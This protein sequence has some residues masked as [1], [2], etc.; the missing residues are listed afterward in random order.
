MLEDKSGFCH[1]FSSSPNPAAALDGLGERFE[2]LLD[3]IKA[4]PTINCSQAPI[5]AML[6]IVTRNDVAPEDI[7][8]IHLTRMLRPSSKDQGINYAPQ[9]V[10][11]ARL[12]IPF[13]LS[14]A[15]HRRAV[16]LEEFTPERLR[17]PSIGALM[18][19]V[20]IVMDE[21]LNRDYPGGTAAMVLRVRLK[22]GRELEQFVR[23]PKGN[24]NEPM[25]EAEI[26]RKFVALAG[27][28]LAPERVDDLVRLLEQ[29]ENQPDMD[30]VLAGSCAR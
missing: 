10:L 11:A 1:A 23:Y 24:P 3:I 17:D 6:E 4:Y 29:L 7:E 30:A 21:Q 13:C 2:I 8:R 16:T 12:S 27:R 28:T 5:Q 14:L 19:K 18:H 22:D 26:R 15:A 20:E 25:S 9:T